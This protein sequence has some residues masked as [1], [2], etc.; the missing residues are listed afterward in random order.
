MSSGSEKHIHWITVQKI[1]NNTED[2]NLF[3]HE[4]MDRIYWTAYTLCRSD[5]LLSNCPV[6]SVRPRNIVQRL[7][8]KNCDELSEIVLFLLEAIR[9]KIL[10]LYQGECSLSTFLFPV[11]N[12]VKEQ[13]HNRGYGYYQLQA[14]YI[15][16]KKGRIRLPQPIKKLPALQQ[17]MYMLLARGWDRQR[18]A[19][20]L[21]ISESAV[22]EVEHTYFDELKRKRTKEI[23]FSD[24]IE[25][26]GHE[27]IPFELPDEHAVQC[28]E[29]IYIDDLKHMFQKAFVCLDQEERLIL[30]LRYSE[31][32]KVK[33]VAEIMGIKKRQIYAIEKRAL[34]KLNHSI[35]GKELF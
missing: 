12:P 3:V 32:L 8:R 9:Y 15:R 26:N 4:Y 19:D 27:E 33:N 34:R 29:R 18:I 2:W 31:N 23:L 1:L 30:R 10:P 11:L 6:R 5:C 35:G 17:E 7:S 14:D 24:L 25:A 20:H 13:T 21:S 28:H 16:K 22:L